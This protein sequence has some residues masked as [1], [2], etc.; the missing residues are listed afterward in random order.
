M[1]MPIPRH[2]KSLRITLI[3]MLLTTLAAAAHGSSPGI[4]SVITN[5]AD[6]SFPQEKAYLHLDNT[7]YYQG[8]NIWFSAYVV[9]AFGNTAPPVSNTLY[10]ELLTPGGEVISKK[11]LKLENGRGHGDFSLNHLPFYSGYY[12]IRAYTKHMLNFGEEAIYSRVIPIFERPETD[13]DFASR[14]MRRYG[15]GNFTYNRKKPQKG[16]DVNMAFFPEGGNMVNGLPS[17]VAFEITDKLGHPLDA[18]GIIATHDGTEVAS[19]STAHDGKGKFMYMPT[20]EKTEAIVEYEGK[21]HKFRLPEALD[22]GYVMTVNNITNADSVSIYIS[23]SNNVHSHDTLAIALMS[24]GSLADCAVVRSNFTTQL[25]LKLS[26]SILPSGVSSIALIDNCGNILCERMIFKPDT[27]RASVTAAFDKE[28]Y[29]PFE[30]VRLSMSLHDAA[31]SPVTSPFSIAVRDGDNELEWSR[32]IQTDLLLMSD[33]KGYVR[34]PG[35]YFESNDIEHRYALDLLMMVQGWRRHLRKS[36]PKG[37]HELKYRPE[38][39]GIETVGIVSDYNLKKIKPGVQISAFLMHRD[40]EEEK[41]TSAMD[42]LIADS[43]GRFSFTSNVYGDWNMIL[44][45]RDKGKSKDYLVSI[46]RLFSPQPRQYLPTEMEATP[47]HEYKASSKQVAETDSLPEED[48]DQIIKAY[49]DSAGIA[50]NKVSQLKEVVVKAKKNSKEKSIYKARSKSV[51]YYDVN[52]GLDEIRD[53]GNYIGD[54]INTFLR[55]M[56]KN[57]TPTFV[58][59]EEFLLYKGKEPLFVINYSHSMLTHEDSIK[60][61]IIGLET[62]KSIYISEDRQTMI[63]YCD[64][65]LSPMSVDTQYGCAVLIE[66][67]PEDEVPVSAGKGV[68]KTRLQGYSIPSEFYNPDYSIMEPEPDDYR[69]TLYWNPAAI[70]DENGN[71]TIEFYNNSKC[72]HLFPDVQSVTPDGLMIVMNGNCQ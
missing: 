14:K 51:A 28:S 42:L 48:I 34:N 38:T 22:T 7:G 64:P 26:N 65:K 40:K 6:N 41:N 43:L 9:N 56:N 63:A 12:E 55:K 57:F 25:K 24:H 2:E 61:K 20:G 27:C 19:F 66:T 62:I 54:N 21:K 3:F 45:V 70:P 23:R 58:N 72:R 29:K 32:N 59:G 8:D 10:V 31:G 17:Q 4:D 52:S 11:I 69:R 16:K 30:R 13:G 44:A 15:S 5:L 53:K 33:I 49:E 35:Y 71:A 18:S 37:K 1:F 60:Y 46:D 47:L 39:E 67:Y 68:R 50:H 36:L